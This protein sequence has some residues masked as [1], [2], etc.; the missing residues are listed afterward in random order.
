[1]VLLILELH[2]PGLESKEEQQK[3]KAAAGEA[4]PFGPGQTDHEKAD[5]WVPYLQ[6][7]QKIQGGTVA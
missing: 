4:G 2:G 5:Q 7:V 3:T 1:M 6:R